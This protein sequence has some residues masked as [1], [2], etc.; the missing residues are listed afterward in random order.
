MKSHVDRQFLREV[1]KE[2][3]TMYPFLRIQLATSGSEKQGIAGY[4]GAD[5]EALR[6]MARSLLLNDLQ[7]NDTMKVRDLET[8]LKDTL[9]TIVQIFRKSGNFWIETKMTRDWTLKQQN[10]YGRELI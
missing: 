5:N 3:N 10:D 1:E 2:F 7:V 6:S 8:G 9:A 4:Q